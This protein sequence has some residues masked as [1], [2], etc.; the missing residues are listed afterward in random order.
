[1]VDLTAQVREIRIGEDARIHLRR[2]DSENESPA[3]EERLRAAAGG[4]ADIDA[5][6][7][8]A[9]GELRP[10]QSFFEL[11]ECARRRVRRKSEGKEPAGIARMRVGDAMKT[12]VPFVLFDHN[13][14]ENDFSQFAGRVKSS[15]VGAK[16]RAKSSRSRRHKLRVQRVSRGGQTRFEPAN[17]DVEAIAFPDVN[18]R[19]RRKFATRAASV[20]RAARI[21][22]KFALRKLPN[23]SKTFRAIET[24][25]GVRTFARADSTEGMS[26]RTR[27]N[28]TK[29]RNIDRETLFRRL[30]RR[31][32][33]RQKTRPRI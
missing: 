24:A 17:A 11:E 7:T 30:R 15:R 21:R 5:A 25:R 13:D 8:H 12:D 23:A 20:E 4:R 19:E 16:R 28:E 22:A 14:V 2:I 18:A 6:R 27:E 31:G 29:R 33:E 32:A 26:A 10:S 3:R 1:M 9:A